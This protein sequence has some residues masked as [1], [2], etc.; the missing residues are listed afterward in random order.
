MD[1]SI[2]AVLPEN[3]V[4]KTAEWC[5]S[6][7]HRCRPR[8]E[9]ILY[10]EDEMFVREVT[11]DV[12]ESAGYRVLSAKDSVE[13][14][15]LYDTQGSEV[16]LVLTDVILPGESGRVLAAKLR[17]ENRQLKV[18]FVTGYVEQMTKL[19]ETREEWLA[20]PFSS[21]VL[22]REIRSLLD[23]GKLRSERLPGDFMPACADA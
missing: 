20:K 12:L 17:R 21:D 11:C 14:A 3:S 13:A 22:L 18:L 6:A 2:T 10:V 4:E 8:T 15:R 16:D 7:N 1:Q 23:R 19:E 9:T 5:A